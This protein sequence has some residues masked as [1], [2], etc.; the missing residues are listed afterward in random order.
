MPLCAM[1]LQTERGVLSAC[2]L[3][4]AS[5]VWLLVAGEQRHTTK[6]RGLGT[7]VQ[8]AEPELIMIHPP[9]Q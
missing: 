3:R 6:Q 8:N 5:W 4:N 9:Q 1:L 2:Q 7:L